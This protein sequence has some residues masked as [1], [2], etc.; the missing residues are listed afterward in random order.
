MKEFSIAVF[1]VLTL[2]Q[3]SVSESRFIVQI[4]HYTPPNLSQASKPVVQCYGTVI[5][6]NH[7]L[8]TAKCISPIETEK[9]IAIKVQTESTQCK[10]KY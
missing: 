2:V 8:T 4:V 1:I 9:A 10:L 7:V 6:P 5:S 3:Q